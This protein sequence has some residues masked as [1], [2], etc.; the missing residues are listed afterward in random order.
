MKYQKSVSISGGWVK[1]NDL[2]NGQ[3]AKIVSETTAQP[4]SFTDKKGNPKTQDV[5]K[6]R[7]E[8]QPEAVNVSL[9]R[10][11]INALIDAYGE[12][13]VAWQGHYLTCEIEKVRVAGVM[14]LALYLLPEGFEKA[15]DENGYAVVQRK[16]IQQGEAVPQNGP[17]TETE[18]NVE[19]IPF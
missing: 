12:D 17:V 15:D 1:T 7:F 18:I 13:S 5:A 8:G 10:A 19:D 11:T 14:R 16:A 4:S 3:K 6:I 2:K 9:N